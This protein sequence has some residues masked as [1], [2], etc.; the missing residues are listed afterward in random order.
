MKIELRNKIV[1]DRKYF[2]TVGKKIVE[3]QSYDELLSVCEAFQF[4]YL[5]S[6]LSVD[7]I[8]LS[9][10]EAGFRSV[11]KRVID[12]IRTEIYIGNKRYSLNEIKNRFEV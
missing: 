5:N 1:L 4:E 8:N 3:V 10:E 12:E 9:V 2:F 7:F 11:N 6:L